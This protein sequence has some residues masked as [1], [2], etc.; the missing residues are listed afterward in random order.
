MAVYFES[1]EAGPPVEREVLA[2]LSG[3]VLDLGAGS[4]RF[5]HAALQR[6]HPV[7]AVDVLTDAVH[8]LRSRSVP[9]VLGDFTHVSSL[10]PAD[11]VLVLMNGSTHAGT[12]DGLPG[13]LG[14]LRTL[15]RPGGC[16]LIDSTDPGHPSVDWDPPGDGRA[17]GELHLQIGF[18][19]I[20]GPPMP[21]L[22]L[23]PGALMQAATD[24]GLTYRTLCMDDDGRYLAELRPDIHDGGSAVD[25]P[26][27]GAQDAAR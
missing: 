2:R 25:T 24:E 20:W 26:V 17:A 3:S 13:F 6:G 8:V 19:G 16:I 7:L 12:L 5:A 18:R 22:F 11:T 27:P 23:G 15:V 1:P 9:C 4:G 10:A 21:Q 14:R